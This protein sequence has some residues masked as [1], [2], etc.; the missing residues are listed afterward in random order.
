M[1]RRQ[2]DDAGTLII[3]SVTYVGMADAD[4]AY[5]GGDGVVY[6]NREEVKDENGEVTGYKYFNEDNDGNKTYY[7][8]D[9]GTK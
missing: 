6:K 2:I 9:E 8:G 4:K 3:P 7:G 1:E 5:V